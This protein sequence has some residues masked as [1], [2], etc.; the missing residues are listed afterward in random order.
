[1]AL[2][3]TFPW[4]HQPTEG[5]KK[6][7]GRGSSS[8]ERESGSS[9]KG[10]AASRP[11][12]SYGWEWLFVCLFYLISPWRCDREE[13]KVIGCHLGRTTTDPGKSS[14]TFWT[15]SPCRQWLCSCKHCEFAALANACMLSRLN[16]RWITPKS[17][18]V[19]WCVEK[20]KLVCCFRECSKGIYL[21]LSS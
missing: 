20:V 17:L 2:K 11:P 5:E 1:M 16:R 9:G 8:S 10:G 12:H 4:K 21:N 18:G 7:E 6:G 3:N 15:E 19:S 14:H 13:K